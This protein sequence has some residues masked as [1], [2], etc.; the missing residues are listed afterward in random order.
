MTLIYEETQIDGP[1]IHAFV[2]GVGAYPD[3]KRGRGVLPE[4]RAVADVP[5]AA[6]SA[7]FM[8]DWIVANRERFT[9]RLATVEVVISDPDTA[10]GRYAWDPA[11][12]IEGATAANVARAG[13]AWLTRLNERVG[14]I[15]LFY[16]CG[17][18]AINAG[19]P[20]LFL[21]DL[22]RDESNPWVHLN[23]WTLAQS[24]RR[25]TR[26]G[27]A[28]MFS[29]A[30]AEFVTKFE[31]GMAME[32]R[33]FPAPLSNRNTRNN[34]SLICAASEAHLAYD[35][36]RHNE[37]E[38]ESSFDEQMLDEPGVRL[39]RFTQVLVKALDGASARWNRNQWLVEP[40]ALILD[41][42]KIRRHFFSRWKER[43]FE[44]IAYLTPNDFY[45]IVLCDGHQVPILVIIDPMERMAVCD[46]YVSEHDDLDQPWL[47]HRAAGDAGAW[48]T[49]VPAARRPFY[50]IVQFE[51]R[52]YSL[53]FTPEPLSEQLVG[54]V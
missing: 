23:M 33:F 26:I 15:A 40:S 4:L 17:H 31:L 54:L 14:D 9:A 7:K 28:F 46:L 10:L 24:L 29:D 45:P 16:C 49:S 12:P 25:N 30:C 5:S 41:L 2:M 36:E 39:G 47:K 19:H 35:G 6:D 53:F 20:V 50:A 8:C 11:V 43:V 52:K 51:H 38:G 48:L 32:C 42:R 18:G 34:V 22:N 27:N 21:E 1:R 13:A 3:A 44:P 37:E